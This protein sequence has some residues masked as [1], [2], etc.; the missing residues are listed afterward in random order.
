MKLYNM[1]SLNKLI[2]NPDQVII[3][4]DKPQILMPAGQFY[5]QLIRFLPNC[6]KI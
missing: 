4:D 5:R 2:P 6:E 3:P 1:L